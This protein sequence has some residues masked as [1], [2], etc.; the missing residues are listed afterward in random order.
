MMQDPTQLE[1]LKHDLLLDEGFRQYPYK[2]INGILTIGIGRNLEQKG[3]SLAE[4]KGLLQNDIAETWNELVKL[5]PWFVNLDPIRQNVLMNLAFNLGVSGLMG[6]KKTLEYAKKADFS[7]A[8]KELLD[9]KA[10]RQLQKRYQRLAYELE[11][12]KYAKT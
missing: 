11:F 12:G 2:D 7:N 5:I 6:F 8:A 1:N 3:I 10:A 9:S 4:A